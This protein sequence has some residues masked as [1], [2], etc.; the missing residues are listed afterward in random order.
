M[1]GALLLGR[2]SAAQITIEGS[3]TYEI[4]ANVG[5]SGNGTLDLRLFTFSGSEADNASGG[6]NFDNAVT[7]LPQGGGSP[8]SF[9]DAYFTSFSKL[10][11][12]HLLNFPVNTPDELV[13]FFDLNEAGNPTETQNN[14]VTQLRIW[15]SPTVPNPVGSGN[16]DP[17]ANDISSAQMS[18]IG[19]NFSGGTLIAAFDQSALPYT[20]PVVNQGAGFADFVIF[21]GVNPFDSAFDG[22][23]ILIEIAMDGLSSGA[24]EFYLSGKHSN[25]DLEIALGIEPVPEPGTLT[26]LGVSGLAF[27]AL[28]RRRKS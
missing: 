13:L 17:A 4:P 23:N 20:L 11:A 6:A 14:Q 8:S 24:E 10:R 2:A 18:A 27:L 28:R 19:T 12:Y 3:D 1:V 26:L 7:D 16:L 25:F 21:T 15:S 22:Q 9:A 5:A